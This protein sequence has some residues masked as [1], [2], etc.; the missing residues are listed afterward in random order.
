VAEFGQKALVE[1]L[2]KELLALSTKWKN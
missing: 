2:A 1:R